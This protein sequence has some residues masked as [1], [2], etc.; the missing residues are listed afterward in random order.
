M[1][2][3][4]DAL[5]AGLRFP[6]H[7]LIEECLKWWRIS[8]SQVAPNSWRYLVV[9][10]GECRGAGIIPT[11]DLFMTC[12]RLCKSWGGYYI[13]ARVGF[14]VS[15]APSSNKG[16]KS[17][18]LYVSG[19]GWGFGLSW[20]ARPIGNAPPY[21]S[22]EETVLVG[23]LKGILSSSRAIKEMTELWL[24]EAGL[25][26]ASRD[27]M[28]LGELR[29]MPRVTGGKA[30]PSRPT[31]REVGASPAREALSA[32]LKRPAPPTEQ[33]EVAGKQ[34]KKTK[35]LTRKHKSYVGEGGV[36]FPLQG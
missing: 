5:E 11:R 22:E 17:R 24:A 1:C 8:P 34:Q 26:P 30:P 35:V 27:R 19:L 18:Y 36:P 13:T 4:V 10:L 28:D 20:S 2:I 9:F 12:F 29:G 33:A 23:Q 14:R 16:W 3:S 31:A 15:G 25:S 21:L 7:P 6:L 32:S